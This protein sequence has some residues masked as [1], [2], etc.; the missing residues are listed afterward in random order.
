MGQ[1]LPPRVGGGGLT[2]CE[3]GG[4]DEQKEE[5]KKETPERKKE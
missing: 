1:G 4:A 3:I 2:R 5:N